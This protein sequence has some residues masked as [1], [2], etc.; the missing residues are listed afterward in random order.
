MRTLREQLNKMC[1]FKVGILILYSKVLLKRHQGIRK[2]MKN[3]AS[4]AKT[5]SDFGDKS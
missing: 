4:P 5:F 1:C 3:K 2:Q